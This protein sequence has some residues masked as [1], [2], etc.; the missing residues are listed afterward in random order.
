MKG[1]SKKY[2]NLLGDSAISEN[3]ANEISFARRLPKY[4]CDKV[5]NHILEV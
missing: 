3:L 4:M 1:D 5:L 2:L